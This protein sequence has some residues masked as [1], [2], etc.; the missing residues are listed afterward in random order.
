MNAHYFAQFYETAGYQVI[1]TKTGYWYSLSP[2][3][4]QSLPPNHLIDPSEEELEQL[5][6][7]SKLLGA[8]FPSFRNAGTE[9]GF[10]V[11][12]DK[13]YGLHF[14]QRQFRQHVQKGM[15]HCEVREIDFDDLYRHD[16][17]VNQDAMARR[18]YKMPR[19]TDPKLWRR[20]CDA[21]KNTPGAGTKG[22][23]IQGKLASYLMYFL[24]DKTCHGLHMMSRADM[25]AYCPNHALYYEYTKELI[26]REGV[27]AVT[28]GFQAVPPLGQVD[29]F[30]R[31]AGYQKEIFY[32]SLVLRPAIESLLLNR[33]TDAVLSIAVRVA[34]HKRILAPVISNPR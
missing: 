7:Q 23:F 25:R 21:G 31:H 33:M 6:R 26:S 12:R 20:F 14:T 30:K 19:F 22:S 27:E 29:Q 10:F 8:Q 13:G 24:A 11:V 1:R 4:Y 28:T 16:M 3:I 32:I 9:T 2:Y 34:R 15:R 17:S 18:K 5:F